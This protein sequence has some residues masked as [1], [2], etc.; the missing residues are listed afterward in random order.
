MCATVSDLRSCV[1]L[2]GSVDDVRGNSG[3]DL[4]DDGDLDVLRVVGS[5]LVVA[6]RLAGL[7]RRA[8]GR[9]PGRRLTPCEGVA[10]APAAGRHHAVED[11]AE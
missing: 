2:D 6:A 4:A 9:R 10:G 1:V 7:S 8:P 3:W 11:R 5:G